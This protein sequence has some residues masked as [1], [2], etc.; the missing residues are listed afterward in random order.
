MRSC[1][2]G[3]GGIGCG[4]RVQVFLAPHTRALAPLR[5]I[6]T[7]GS[8]SLFP[9]TDTQ[10]VSEPTLTRFVSHRRIKKMFE[11]YLFGAKPVMC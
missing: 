10:T 5:A 11:N 3:W 6:E 2:W 1:Y 7:Q 8:W 4:S 9:E